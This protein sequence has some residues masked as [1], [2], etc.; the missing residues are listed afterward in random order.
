MLGG[1]GMNKIKTILASGLAV[2]AVA[3]GI[4]TLVIV[5]K[6]PTTVAVQGAETSTQAAAPVQQTELTYTAVRG[7]N[8]LDQTKTYATVETQDSAYGPF[9]TAIN[10]VKGG[11]DNKYWSFYVN[12]ALAQ[13]GAADYWPDGGEKITWKLE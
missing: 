9:V 10:G 3:L 8:I 7:T 4:A 1:K 12:D 2:G 13:K 6:K 11:T 5:A